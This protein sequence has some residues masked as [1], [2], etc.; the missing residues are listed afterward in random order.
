[1]CVRVLRRCSGGDVLFCV[2]VTLI[3]NL[4]NKLRNKWFKRF[5]KRVFSSSERGRAHLSYTIRT[6]LDLRLFCLSLFSKMD[7][8]P[9]IHSCVFVWIADTKIG[10]GIRNGKLRNEFF[11]FDIKWIN[12]NKFCRLV[13]M[14]LNHCVLRCFPLSLRYVFHLLNHVNLSVLN[15]STG[16]LTTT[17]TPTTAKNLN[18]N[19]FSIRA[20]LRVSLTRFC[21]LFINVISLILYIYI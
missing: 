4:N 3:F 20:Y 2:Q 15:E 12:Q 6:V 9:L 1:M 18:N 21:L 14:G 7:L 10:C 19:N 13:R 5:S 16:P 8:Y 11:F 17:P